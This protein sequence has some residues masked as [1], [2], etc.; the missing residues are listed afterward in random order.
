[1][2]V[3]EGSIVTSDNLLQ[4]I[5]MTSRMQLYRQ[6]MKAKG[7]MQVTVWAR[8]EEADQVRAYAA[9][10]LADDSVTSPTTVS[11]S[12]GVKLAAS[13]ASAPTTITPAQ[14]GSQP[15]P[16]VQQDQ[17]AQPSVVTG[18]A[19]QAQQPVST[20]APSSAGNVSSIA[21]DNFVTSDDASGDSD[22]AA[23]AV[24]AEA[25][26]EVASEVAAWVLDMQGMP[27]I[28]R[29][30]AVLEELRDWLKEL[31]DAALPLRP[32]IEQTIN[33]HNKAYKKLRRASKRR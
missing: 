13:D 14:T 4:A 20:T 11:A 15:A 12:D 6:R 19:M 32:A 18:D 33:E 25:L 8:P 5:A 26:A 21:S 9:G 7:L 2:P 27:E 23:A 22:V 29:H 24:S 30:A 31:D 17:Q 1:M 10:L 28:E 3:R 16:T